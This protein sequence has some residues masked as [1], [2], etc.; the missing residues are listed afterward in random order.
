MNSSEQQSARDVK[1][2]IGAEA[3]ITFMDAIHKVLLGR[4]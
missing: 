3:R 2:I 1:W 4:S